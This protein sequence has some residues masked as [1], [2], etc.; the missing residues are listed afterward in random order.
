MEL[1]P[2]HISIKRRRQEEPVE[3]LYLE[4]DGHQTKRRFTE[5]CFQRVKADIKQPIAPNAL[6]GEN[7]REEGRVVSNYVAS[8]IPIVRATSPGAEIREEAERRAAQKALR[9]RFLPEEHSSASKKPA[10]DVIA[11]SQTVR[12]S[13]PLQRPA[14]PLRHFHLDHGH[15]ASRLNQPSGIRK[16]KTARRNYLA[17]FIESSKTSR[18]GSELLDTLP[19]EKPIHRPQDGTVKSRVDGK[20]VDQSLISMPTRVN[21]TG[22][23]MHDHPSSWDYDSDQLAEELAAFAL[24]ISREEGQEYQPSM[25]KMSQG[26]GVKDI[27]VDVDED[28]IYDTYIRV[29]VAAGGKGVASPNDVGLLIIDDKDQE[30]WRTFAESD[31]D[32][33]W[34]EDDP[35]SNAEDNPANEYPDEEVDSGDEHGYGAYK[36]R[37]LASEDEEYDLN[38]PW[39]SSE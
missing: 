19:R 5:Y 33:E 21:K 24:E 10:R 39:S 23:S 12:A 13:T 32:S 2:E 27:L 3:L 6:S 20:P 25:T 11:T 35:D 7:I 14:A 36:N 38:D 15:R 4:S 31:D 29:P 30:L 18:Q 9:G 28:F 37:K 22:Q 8:G 17:T 34:D 26:M 16:R 1:P